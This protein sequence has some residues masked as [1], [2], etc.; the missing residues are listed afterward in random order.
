LA[1]LGGEFAILTDLVQLGFLIPVGHIIPFWLFLAFALIV[2]GISIGITG[3]LTLMLV[4]VLWTSVL[5]GGLVILG[6]VFG[7][8][9]GLAREFTASFPIPLVNLLDEVSEVVKALGFVKMHHL[10]FYSL[11]QSQICLAVQS[12]I[13]VLKHGHKSVEVNKKP[14]CLMVILHDHILKLYFGIGDLVVR[15][16]IQV[17]LFHEWQVIWSPYGFTGWVICKVWLEI[18]KSYSLEEKQ[19]VVH[20]RRTI[21]KSLGFGMEI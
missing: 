7:G 11:R 13:G 3:T 12:Q 21:S 17:K 16:E 14:N 15:A 8:K 20:F 2:I 9:M 19:A 10:V 6:L 18:V 1:F 4:I 5:V